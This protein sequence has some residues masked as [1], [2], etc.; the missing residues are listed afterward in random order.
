MTVVQ[1]FPSPIARCRRSRRSKRKTIEEKAAAKTRRAEM[2]N[3][4]YSE[5]GARL[6]V[7]RELLGISQQEAAAAFYVSLRTYRRWEKGGVQSGTTCRGL[8]N[9]CDTFNVLPEWL[10]G[11]PKHGSPPRFKPRLVN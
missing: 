1:L 3:M 2:K 9:F 11:G 6:R 7:C 5:V 4:F 8:M 10:L